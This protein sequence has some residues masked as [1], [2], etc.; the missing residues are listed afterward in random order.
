[1]DAEVKQRLNALLQDLRGMDAIVDDAMFQTFDH[2]PRQ[3]R[4]ETHVERPACDGSDARRQ[5][6][7]KTPDCVPWYSIPTTTTTAA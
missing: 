6:S 3:K 7:L 1:M 2:L 5:Q 4:R